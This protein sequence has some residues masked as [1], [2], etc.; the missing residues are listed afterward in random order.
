MKLNQ[1]VIVILIIVALMA[2]CTETETGEN[3][4][5][6]NVNYIYEDCV[7]TKINVYDQFTDELRWVEEF[8]YDQGKLVS[9]SD[10]RGW[11]HEFTYQGNNITRMDRLDAN[12]VMTSYFL[13]QYSSSDQIIKIQKFFNTDQDPNMIIE[14]ELTYTYDN[15][16][17]QQAQVTSRGLNGSIE[18]F[19][20]DDIVDSIHIYRTDGSLFARERFEW[21]DTPSVFR[22]LNYIPDGL[23]GAGMTPFPNPNNLIRRSFTQYDNSGNVLLDGATTANYIDFNAINYPTDFIYLNRY[24][25]EY[26]N[27]Q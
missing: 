12:D 2:A 26:V 9:L 14:E 7:P 25:V 19:G 5:A 11:R 16:V 15:G 21:E 23:I 27:C 22:N 24:R 4:P 8:N 6:E 18:Y 17:I 1:S 13:Y 3:N 20:I 10:T